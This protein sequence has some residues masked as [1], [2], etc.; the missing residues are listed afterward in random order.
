MIDNTTSDSGNLIGQWLCDTH[1]HDFGR[2]AIMG[3]GLSSRPA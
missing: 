3:F 1:Q 2:I